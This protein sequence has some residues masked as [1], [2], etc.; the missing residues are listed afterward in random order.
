MNRHWIWKGICIAILLPLGALLLGW[1]LMT[2]WNWLIPDLFHGPQI[3]YLQGI[4]LF[5]LAK[6]LFGKGRGFGC[7]SWGG[8]NC[9]HHHGHWRRGHWRARWEE[10][11]STMSPEEREKFKQNM[12]MCGCNYDDEPKQEQK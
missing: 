1:V 5:I 3:N 2:L 4:G 9:C 6:L 7:G 11:L 8:G 10:R 12:R